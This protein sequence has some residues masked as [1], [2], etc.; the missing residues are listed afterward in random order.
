[1][2]SRLLELSLADPLLV[3]FRHILT[4][5][6]DDD[7]DCF[8]DPLPGPYMLTLVFA[9]ESDPLLVSAKASLKRLD[10]AWK[11]GHTDKVGINRRGQVIH[12]PPGSS[13]YSCRE[14]FAHGFRRLFRARTR[15]EQIRN[16]M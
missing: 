14:N 12:L 8:R 11:R 16:Q 10:E 6:D 7:Y 15:K 5:A 2:A 13:P 3:A 4:M 1:M 9:D